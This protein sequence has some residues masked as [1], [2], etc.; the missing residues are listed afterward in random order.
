MTLEEVRPTIEQIV[1]AASEAF[2]VESAVFSEEGS[3]FF[4]TPTYRKK[5]GNGIHQ[6]FIQKVV[7]QGNILVTDPGRMAS[8]VGC[9]FSGHCPSTMEILCCIHAG[10]QIAGVISFTVFTKKGQRQLMEHTSVYL[11]SISKLASLIGRYLAQ[12]RTN[13]AAAEMDG[14]TVAMMELCGQPLLLADTNGV[15][16]RSNGLAANALKFCNI[17]ATSLRQLF[18]EEVVL[19]ITSGN[20]LREK[21]V[22]IGEKTARVSSRAIYA[23][24]HVASVLVRLSNEFLDG[25]PETASIRK[26]IGESKG[27]QEIRRIIR[28]VAV[29]PTPVLLTGETGTGKELVARAIHEESG[30]RNYPFVA[31]NCSSIPENLFESELFG[32][33]EGAFTGAKKGGKAGKIELAQGGTLFLD[34]IGEMPLAVQPKLLRVLQEHEVERV[35]S[36]KKI[37]LDIRII[38]ATNQDLRDMIQKKSF[39]E[40]LF[41]RIGVINLKLPPLR[42]RTADI[43]PITQEYLM[44]LHTKMQTPLQKLSPMAE[45]I[46]LA[47]SWPGNI[48]ELQNVLEYAANF[49]ETDTLLPQDLPEYLRWGAE[50][51]RTQR[52]GEISVTVTDDAPSVADKRLLELLAQYGET[53]EGKKKA[54]A[55][56]GISLRTL[57]RK[58]D[59]LAKKHFY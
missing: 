57:Y 41:Y 12:D 17:Q 16:L 5:K 34:E 54:A 6:L 45:R 32:Y 23:D 9:R 37:Y 14:L 26:L 20:D 30:R 19:R 44:T 56:L 10:T 47:Y 4:C 52:G 39:R 22:A 24:G 15:I 58:I 38:A 50:E 51:I 3:L 2:Q 33:E 40:D 8:C 29:N 7:E 55:A 53:L 49:C 42:E 31:I 21:T 36:S 46:L 18:A 59:R 28:R 27:L 48:R 13:Q 43:L 1:T 35:G 25:H 11:D